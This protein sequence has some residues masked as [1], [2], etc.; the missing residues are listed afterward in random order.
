MYPLLSHI[1]KWRCFIRPLHGRAD[2]VKHFAW[3]NALQRIPYK[4]LG[5]PASSQ[6]GVDRKGQVDV[7]RSVLSADGP[8]KRMSSFPRLNK[9][10]QMCPCLT[11]ALCLIVL[12]PPNPATARPLL[13]LLH[14]RV[15]L[16]QTNENRGQ[17]I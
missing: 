3:L 6:K 14:E 2:Q 7:N 4:N 8:L 10:A 17:G 13:P 9:I 5:V 11:T 12:W 15:S 1:S 16:G